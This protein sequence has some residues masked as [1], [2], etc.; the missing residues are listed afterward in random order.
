MLSEKVMLIIGYG[1][2]GAAVGRIAKF[3]FGTCVIGL[4]R[5]PEEVNPD[6][7]FCAD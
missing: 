1:S 3:G 5:R 4:K 6:A 2:I 7:R